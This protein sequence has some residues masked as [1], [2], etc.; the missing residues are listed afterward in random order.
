MP[1]VDLGHII[2]SKNLGQEI[3]TPI[4]FNTVYV[5][6]KKNGNLIFKGSDATK[7]HGYLK[8]EPNTQ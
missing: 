1:E 4:T 3:E 2:T 6:D 8:L 5:D 7:H